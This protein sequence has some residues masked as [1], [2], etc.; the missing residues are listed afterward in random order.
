MKITEV[1]KKYIDPKIWIGLIKLKNLFK[2][3]NDE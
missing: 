2:T 1:E 3:K